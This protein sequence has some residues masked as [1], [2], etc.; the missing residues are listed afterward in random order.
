M[1]PYWSWCITD[2][3]SHGPVAKQPQKGAK[4]KRKTNLL[5]EFVPATMTAVLQTSHSFRNPGFSV[6]LLISLL[7]VALLSMILE[8]LL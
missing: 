2:L 8:M 4:K 3:H 5:R 7:L 1:F 6:T